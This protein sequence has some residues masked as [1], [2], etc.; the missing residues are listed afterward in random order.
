MIRVPNFGGQHTEKL[1]GSDDLFGLKLQFVDHKGQPSQSLDGVVVSQS[2]AADSQ[3]KKGSAV[4]LTVETDTVTVPSIVGITLD[5]AVAK[6]EAA[7]LLI[8]TTDERYVPDVK[9]G[10]IVEQLPV[11]GAKAPLGS[12]IDVTIASSASLRRA[13]SRSPPSSP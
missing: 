11:G 12:R 4:T 10:T 9:P 3:V 13:I 1:R 7:G 2:P 8:S 5:Q 6:L